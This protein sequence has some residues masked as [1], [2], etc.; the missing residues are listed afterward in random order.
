M[1]LWQRQFLKE[2]VLEAGKKEGVEGTEE[3]VRSVLQVIFYFF[4]YS[5][6]SS[7]NK[8]AFD[9]TNPD[10]QHHLQLKKNY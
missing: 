7:F 5:I 8:L 1:D 4:R 2:A 6:R 3:H 10:Q 9:Q